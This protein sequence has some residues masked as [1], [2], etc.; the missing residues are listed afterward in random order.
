MVIEFLHMVY[1]YTDFQYMVHGKS[2][3]LILFWLGLKITI[4]RNNENIDE[5]FDFLKQNLRL[6]NYHT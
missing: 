3:M 1:N 5:H 4:A 6:L 2:V